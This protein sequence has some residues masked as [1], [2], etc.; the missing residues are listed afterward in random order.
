MVAACSACWVV[1]LLSML[2]FG[3]LAMGALGTEFAA[4]ALALVLAVA[5]AAVVK[6]LKSNPT[7]GGWRGRAEPSTAVDAPRSY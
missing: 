4:G 3:G 6:R 5:V 1:P 2:G 7:A